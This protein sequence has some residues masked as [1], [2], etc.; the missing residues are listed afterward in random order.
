MAV[1][2]ITWHYRRRSTG[3]PA[4]WDSTWGRLIFVMAVVLASHRQFVTSSEELGPHALDRDEN[5]RLS[6]LSQPPDGVCSKETFTV[7]GGARGRWGC[8]GLK[9]MAVGADW[10]VN[11]IPLAKRGEL[12]GR[13][14]RSENESH[15]GIP[16]AV[17][18]E[19]LTRP[20]GGA[21][22]IPG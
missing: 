3:C 4:S 18:L 22:P 20:R 19:P 13:C 10:Q 21:E 16:I 7:G 15:W 1:I 5:I 14:Q 17:N 6:L 8:S 12:Q 2:V 11:T 9:K